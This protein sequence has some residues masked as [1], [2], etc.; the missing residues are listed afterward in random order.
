[1][2][3]ITAE[4][5]ERLFVLMAREDLVV[6][7]KTLRDFPSAPLSILI[8]KA[9]REQQALAVLYDQVVSSHKQLHEISGED[10][11]INPHVS[12]EHYKNH[13]MQPIVF[14]MLKW[15][16]H[17]TYPEQK[18]TLA[19]RFDDEWNMYAPLKPPPTEE[20]SG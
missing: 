9:T 13:V 20:K 16:V 1:M 14:E 18:T 10:F 7:E 19:I 12:F 15:S 8:G 2:L 3:V 6:P 4:L 11:G 17:R 5:D